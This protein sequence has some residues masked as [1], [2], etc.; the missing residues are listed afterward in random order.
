MN[1][2]SFLVL[3]FWFFGIK[4]KIPKY[5]IPKLVEGS[6]RWRFLQAWEVEIDP[7]ARLP[8]GKSHPAWIMREPEGRMKAG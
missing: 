5:V 3:G 2:A 4:Q 1:G 8:S 6:Q 7:I